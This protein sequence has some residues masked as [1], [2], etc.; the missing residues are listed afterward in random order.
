VFTRFIH[1]IAFNS[2]LKKV[3]QLRI[4]TVNIVKAHNLQS[5][6]EEM[7]GMLGQY[8]RPSTVQ[9]CDEFMYAVYFAG[10]GGTLHA[11]WATIS[12]MQRKTIDVPS[13]SVTFPPGS[14]PE[15]YK[16]SP[17][18][19]IK[20]TVRLDAPVTSA[21]CVFKEAQT[22]EMNLSC[23]GTSNGYR[24]D[25]GTLHQYVLSVA[26]R[27]PGKFNQPN[28]FDPTRSNIDDMLGWNGALSNQNDYPRICPGQA[29][30][31]T[32]VKAICALLDDVGTPTP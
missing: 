9:L 14:L 28:I 5:K 12:F 20:E 19:F 2:L 26:N 11:T 22:V 13:D 1:R 30:S 16:A 7:N 15:M 8:T 29:M 3:K 24:M 31:I 6:F 25:P 18:N 21:T 32:I 27:D 4:D 17:D 10:V 23:C